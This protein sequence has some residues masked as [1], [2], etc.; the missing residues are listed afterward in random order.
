VS[1]P[2]PYYDHA[3][4][5]I[6]HGDCREI[7]PQAR[8]DLVLTDPPYGIGSWSATGGNS[9]R[10][11]EVAEINRW[12][13][14]PD[15]ETLRRVIGAAGYA[16]IWG[17][18]YMADIL[19]RTRAPLVWDKGIRGM[20]F[21]DG[22]IAWTNFD[23]GTLRIYRLCIASADTKGSRVHPTQKPLELMQWCLG[24]VDGTVLDPFM[25]SGT[26]LVAAKNLGRKAIGIEIEE[27]Y[28]E[29]AAKRL[30]QEVLPL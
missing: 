17:G 15:E 27:R 2:R 4:I 19:G 23:F 18:N 9:L 13:I 12:D 30:A 1:L 28:C 26:T 8:S 6:Y 20:H 21:A 25:G 3:G 5:T 11:E 29:I 24:F 22:E 10:E 7:L 16:I 14:C